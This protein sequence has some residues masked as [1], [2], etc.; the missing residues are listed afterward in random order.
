MASSRS[1]R[2]AQRR[3]AKA[4]KSG[5]SLIGDI[6]KFFRSSRSRGPTFHTLGGAIKYASQLPGGQASHIIGR[7]VHQHSSNR[8]TQGDKGWASLSEWALP[9]YY[10]ISGEDIEDENE[11]Q[12]EDGAESFRVI[13]YG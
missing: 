8:Y 1:R 9:G 5:R 4:V 2:A 3:N 12:F 10:D 13:L 6:G 11:R 7:G